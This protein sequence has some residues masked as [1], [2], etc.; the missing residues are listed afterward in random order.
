VAEVVRDAAVIAVLTVLAGG[1]ANAAVEQSQDG[2]RLSS[3]DGVWWWAITT[4]TTVGYRTA[5]RPRR[6]AA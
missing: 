6:L 5:T 1:L 3:W 4:V 2:E